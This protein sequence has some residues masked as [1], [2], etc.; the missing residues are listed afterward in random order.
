ASFALARDWP[1]PELMRALN[2]VLPEDV[3]VLAAG[4]APDGF[5][6]RRSA[7][8][9]LYR[10][11]LDTGPLQS[12]LRR[13]LAGHVTAAL[14]GEAMRAAT[15]AFL[16]RRDFASL[17]SSGS[18]VKTTVRTIR[19]SVLRASDGEAP[20]GC[21][22]WTYEVEADGFLRKMVRSIVGGLVEAGRG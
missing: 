3:R 21:A 15:A 20:P 4:R 16:G 11:V 8:G 22:S 1:P 17:A 19:R 13:R 10:Y 14:D 6:A 12:P 9:K 18:S 2:A 5:H 7:T